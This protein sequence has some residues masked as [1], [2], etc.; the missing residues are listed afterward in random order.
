LAIVPPN[1]AN[2]IKNSVTVLL[3]NRNTAINE[4][5]KT[6]LNVDNVM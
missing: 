3:G 6:K 5:K 2:I 4:S 1:T